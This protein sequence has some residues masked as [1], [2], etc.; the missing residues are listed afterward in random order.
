MSSPAEAA[1]HA[2]ALDGV[3]GALMMHH[4]TH[5]AQY[6]KLSGTREEA[7][8]LAYI[9]QVLDGY[10]YAT[11]LL[12]HDAYISLPGEARVLADGRSLTAIT[13]SMARSSP[14][15]GITGRL[16]YV[17]DGSDADFA[18]QDVAGCIVLAEGIATP[19]VALR[20]SRAGAVGQL[21]ISPHEHLHEMCLSPVW[22]NPS[23]ATAAN[24]PSTVACTVSEA[25]GAALRQAL[26]RGE[27]PAVTLHAVVDTGWRRT[28][29]LAAELPA[30]PAAQD[31]PFILF[32]GH[33]DTWYQG[34]MDNGTANITMMEVARIC[35]QSR[36]A[37]RRGL[38]LCFWS[39]HSHGR[40]SGSAWYA[41][42]HWDELERRC[43][44]HVNIDSVGAAGA[45]ILSE[46][47]T[48]T[49]LTALA[50]EVIAKQ[51]GQRLRGKR[52]GRGG[53]ESFWG[54]GIPAMFM[55][56][57]EQAPGA[58]KLRHALGWWWHTPGDLLDK[59]DPGNLARD[60]RIYLEV[61]D[62]LLTDAVLPIDH[63]AQLDSLLAELGR[64][65]GAKAQGIAID[66]LEAQA[67]GLRDALGEARARL[68]PDRLNAAIM[69]VCRALVPLDHTRGDRFEHDPALPLPAWPVLD[70]LRRL[71]AAEPGTDAARL[72][73]VSARQARNRVAHALRE[74]RAALG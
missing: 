4:L 69:R 20:A 63:A 16:V 31:E 73:A 18:G 42:T 39:G 10:G 2:V 6:V 70:P 41:D 49:E 25:D 61:L 7:E 35:A 37:W 58:V 17:G 14:P 44:A 8:S 46:A 45:D 66:A 9:R 19:A 5:I 40:Y 22:G 54:I 34:V 59:I 56:F 27:V 68:D 29:I 53:D 72:L 23:E 26:A 11:T 32:S 67:A 71:A 47:P 38:R 30:D 36:S 60:A 21:H 65:D 43:V 74:A 62:R 64:L 50:A 48:A 33:H 24:L 28:P 55:A 15:Q 13:H 12:E 57:S 1:S 3:D 51:S 52:I